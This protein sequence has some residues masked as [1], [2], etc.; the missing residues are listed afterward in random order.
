MRN[1]SLVYV[2]VI[3]FILAACTTPTSL[4][5]GVVTENPV[6]PSPSVSYPSP[7]PEPFTETPVPFPSYPE[8]GTPGVVTPAIPPSGYE[9]QPGDANLERDTVMLEL[10]SSAIFIKPSDPAQA[11]AILNGNLSDPCH[12]VRVVVTPPDASKTID[13]EV[14]SVVDTSSAC[15]TVIKPFSATIPLGSYTSG[16]YTVMVNGEE[17]GTFFGGYG[18]QPGDESL[19][20]GPVTIDMDNSQLFSSDTQPRLASAILQGELPTPCHQLRVVLEATS[21]ENQINLEVYSLYDPQVICNDMTQ[22][23][24]ITYPLG[25]F[26][27]GHYSVYVNGQLLGEFDG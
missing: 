25:S 14:Y 22:P 6:Q 13:L 24:H 3:A 9:P 15:I 18:V 16:E 26:S 5:T 27:N 7:Y 20:T 4:P 17:L 21:S 23:F 12:E 11:E 19:T 10:D 8:P 1:R 2:F